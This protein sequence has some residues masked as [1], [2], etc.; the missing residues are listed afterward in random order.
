MLKLTV[1]A[2]LMAVGGLALA[3]GPHPSKHVD[4]SDPGAMAKIR[5]SN[6]AH[7]EKIHNIVFGLAN[8]RYG[9]VR[10]WLRTTYQ[11]EDASISYFILTTSPGQRD[12]S[13]VLGDTQYYGRVISM[14]GGG[15]VFLI[16][17][18]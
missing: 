10:Q 6:P 12:L 3:A 8:R 15:T 7:Y 14:Q 9:D 5:D 16:R 13:F 18:Q 1:A 17:N 11:V 2:L 4:L